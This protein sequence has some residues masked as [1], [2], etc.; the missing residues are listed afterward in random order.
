MNL[1]SSKI[2]D[3]PDILRILSDAQKYLADQGVD[4]WQDGYPPHKNR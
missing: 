1:I 3:I 4:Q 2:K